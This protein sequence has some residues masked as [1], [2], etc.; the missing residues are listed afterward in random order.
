MNFFCI[1]Q[2][3]ARR[4]GK[5]FFWSDEGNDFVTDEL[6][7]GD[8]SGWLVDEKDAERFDAIWRTSTKDV[9]DEFEFVIA[10]WHRNQDGSIGIEF[11]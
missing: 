6:D 5:V 4:I 7:G 11:E 8:L 9:P 2:S 1:V 3:A 10:R